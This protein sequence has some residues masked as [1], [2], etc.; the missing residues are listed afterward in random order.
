MLMFSNP[1]FNQA[2]FG[3]TPN[4][5][6]RLKQTIYSLAP[7]RRSALSLL[8]EVLSQDPETDELLNQLKLRKEQL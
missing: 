8:R 3:G 4:E 5:T 6:E 7:K 2:P 1:E